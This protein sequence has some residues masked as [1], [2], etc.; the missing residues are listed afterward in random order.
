MPPAVMATLADLHRAVQVQGDRLIAIQRQEY[1]PLLL[2]RLTEIERYLGLVEHPS[3]P[4]LSRRR[5]LE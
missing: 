2:R 1:G 5:P 4:R 3:A